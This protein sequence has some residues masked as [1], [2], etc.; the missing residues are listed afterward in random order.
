MAYNSFFGQKTGVAQ[1]V[2]YTGFLEKRDFF[3]NCFS[4]EAT[5]NFG[6][7]PSE[8]HCKNVESVA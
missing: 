6:V 7:Y 8:F 1:H 4:S 5:L 3:L 2:T